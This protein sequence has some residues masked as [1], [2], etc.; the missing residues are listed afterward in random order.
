MLSSELIIQLNDF[1]VV[2][3]ELIESQ[4]DKPQLQLPIIICIVTH[5]QKFSIFFFCAN[6]NIEFLF[7]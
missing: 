5:I 1:C 3:V 6:G 2:R 4:N 7:R